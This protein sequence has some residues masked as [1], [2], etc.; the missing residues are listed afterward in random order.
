ML[1]EEAR[2]D[3]SYLA[4]LVPAATPIQAHVPTVPTPYS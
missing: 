4:L 1:L 2:L 3:L